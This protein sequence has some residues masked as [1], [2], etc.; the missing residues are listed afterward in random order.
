MGECGAHGRDVMAPED[1]R[2]TDAQAPTRLAPAV[3]E[4]GLCRIELCQG[5]LAALVVRLPLLGERLPAGRAVKESRAEAPFEPRDRLGNRGARD[6][7]ALGGECKAPGL[8]RLHEDVDPLHAIVRH[9]LLVPV[10]NHSV[11]KS[12]PLRTESRA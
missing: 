5:T 3:V 10:G 6:P 1:D 11:D 4:H 9:A 12:T 2:C 8:R 7:H